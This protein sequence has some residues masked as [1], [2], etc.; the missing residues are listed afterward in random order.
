[1]C[2][3]IVSQRITTEYKEG[4]MAVFVPGKIKKKIKIDLF[5]NKFLC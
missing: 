3:R 4:N 5:A 2:K 1:M